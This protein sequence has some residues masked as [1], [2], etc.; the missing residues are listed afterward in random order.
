MKP[1]DVM[2]IVI[3]CADTKPCMDIGAKD[4]DRWHRE[5][6]WLGIGYHL[7]IRRD[8]TIENGRKLT[9]ESIQA[10]A[11][12]KGYNHCSVGICM[13]GGMAEDGKGHED[14]FTD[15]QWDALQTVVKE[16]KRAFPQAK[17]VGHTDLDP[18][19]P[20]PCFDA[21]SWWAGVETNIDIEF[22]LKLD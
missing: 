7:V 4:I 2:Y 5:R 18:H 11:H 17:V 14:N 19:K 20:C 1:S 22:G 9:P 10:G 15:A 21:Q 6:G 3:H 8:G 16:L 12:V 13:A